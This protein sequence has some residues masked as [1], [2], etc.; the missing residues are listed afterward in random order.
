[1]M[2]NCWRLCSTLYAVILNDGSVRIADPEK[3]NLIKELD[4]LVDSGQGRKVFVDNRD[5]SVKI[6]FGNIYIKHES[7]GT[8]EYLLVENQAGI[9]NIMQVIS[10]TICNKGLLEGN[11]WSILFNDQKECL[12]AKEGITIY[13]KAEIEMFRRLSV[14][15]SSKTSKWV[16]GYRYDTEQNVYYFLGEIDSLLKTTGYYGQYTY[17]TRDIDKKYYMVLPAEVYRPKDGETINEV[18][19]NNFQDIK[20]LTKKSMAVKG[21]QF[22]TDDFN[23]MIPLWE[24]LISNWENNKKINVNEFSDRQTY[25]SLKSLLN[26]FVWVSSKDSTKNIYLS[27]KSKQTIS[28]IISNKMLNYLTAYWGQGTSTRFDDCPGDEKTPLENRETLK[29]IFFMENNRIGEKQ[30]SNPIQ[31]FSN[32]YNEL[33]IDVDG[34]A[35]ELLGTFSSELLLENWEKYID[36]LSHVQLNPGELTNG[37][38]D[39]CDGYGGYNTTSLT[40]EEQKFFDPILQYCRET[41]TNAEEYRRYNSGTKSRPVYVELFTIDINTIKR[42]YENNVPEDVAKFLM[43]RKFVKTIFKLKCK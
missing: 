15:C 9:N 4:K 2:E 32:F 6:I 7:F 26:I 20:F 28:Q 36:N 40:D 17:G 31:F 41:S 35:D 33:G 37:F 16:P 1:M 27:E 11:D 30:V 23:G 25:E 24:E 10:E 29:E 5:F 12:P 42:M 43:N 19:K 21:K 14:S 3:K 34:I 22:A 13:N 38:V 18:I 8:D 39:K